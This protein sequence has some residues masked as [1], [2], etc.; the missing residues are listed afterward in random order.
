[1]T[2]RI[3]ALV[4]V[5][6]AAIAAMYWHQTRATAAIVSGLIEADEIRVGSRVGG[7]VKEVLVEEGQAVRKGQL[8]LRLE[9]YDLREKLAEAESNLAAATAHHE[10]LSAGRRSEEVDQAKALRDQAA[11]AYAEVQA[12]PRTQEIE[13]ARASHKLALAE[14]EFADIEYKRT[15][16]L[17]ASKAVSRETFDQVASRRKVAQA[18]VDARRQRLLLLEE[19]SRNEQKQQAKA[20]LDAQDAEW[21]MAAKGFRPQEIAQAKAQMQA[22]QAAVQAIRR[23]L[24]ELEIVAPTD[25]TIEAIELQPGDLIAVNAPVVSLI[26]TAHM[27]VRAYVPETHLPLVAIGTELPV[28]IDGIDRRFTGRVSFVARQGEFTP[29]NVQTPE[30]RGKQVFRIKVLID[31]KSG[32]LRP[33]MSADIDLGGKSQ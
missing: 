8:L 28:R 10:K 16:T 22:A 9:P 13:E 25:S 14:L 7:R 4:A 2:L 3:G 20:K 27:W 31:D 6:L 33:G 29:S 19:G 26:D 24:D 30:E 18:A 32:I 17:V 5:L 23:Q 15:E 11:A 12:G 1:M 21:R